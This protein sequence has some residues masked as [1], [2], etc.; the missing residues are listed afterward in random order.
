[1][2]SRARLTSKATQA[3]KTLSRSSSSGTAATAV[4]PAASKPAIKPYGQSPNRAE[5][6]SANQQSRPQAASIPRFEQINMDLQPQPLS[7]MELI[8]NEPVRLVHGRRAV[9]D[10]GE[11][12]KK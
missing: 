6:W 1:M 9:C 11:K 12:R 4:S 2:L 5:K 10:G 8:D 3:V 7:A